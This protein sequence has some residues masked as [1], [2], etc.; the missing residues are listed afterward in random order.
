[1][2]VYIYIYKPLGN[3]SLKYLIFLLEKGIKYFLDFF[4]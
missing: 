2:C 3:L 4:K 1:M